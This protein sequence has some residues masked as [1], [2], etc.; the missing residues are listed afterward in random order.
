M[1][2]LP[3][4]ISLPTHAQKVAEKVKATLKAEFDAKAPSLF[5]ED[6]QPRWGDEFH[7][8]FWM[9]KQCQPNRFIRGSLAYMAYQ[10]GRS[11]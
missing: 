5:T 2:T 4:K 9:G 7:R 3:K 10:A 8:A 6:G 11:I 1:T